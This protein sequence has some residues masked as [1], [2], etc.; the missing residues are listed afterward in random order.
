MSHPSLP[1]AVI[2]G[3]GKAGT[4]SLFWYLS[5][6]P[7]IC[8]SKIKE[9]R[10]FDASGDDRAV[11][12]GDLERYAAL[13]SHCRGERH[14]LEAS[15]QYFHDGARIAAAMRDTLADVK[16]IVLL[17][18]PIDR[19]WSTFR[20]MRS[21]LADLPEDMTF[22]AYV[23]AC[24]AVRARHEPFSDENR[25]YWTIQGGFYVEYLDP[26]V[27]TFDE[28]FRLV[29]FEDMTA[30]AP[31][32]V[33]GLSSWLDIDPAAASSIVYSVENKTVPVRSASLQ[34]LA[35]ALNREGLLGGHRRLKGP[36]RRA[37]Y[38]LNRRSEAEH[39]SPELRRDLETLFAPGNEA[40]ARRLRGL[41]YDQLPRWL[42]LEPGETRE[43]V[44]R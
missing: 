36:L 5:Q 9:I 25:L 11:G 3:V 1:T 12:S 15:P 34:R 7:D 2:A 13:F 20:F 41:G 22:E 39:M 43:P 4:T 16:V 8:A 17:R 33:R 21:R 35:L 10:Y 40:L 44:T 32:T 28:R 18:D 42:S 29:F 6:H 31:A 38:A 19:L 37:Y 26:W 23:D 27:E 14:R 24:R 30:D